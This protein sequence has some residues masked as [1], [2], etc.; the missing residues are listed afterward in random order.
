M[1]EILKIIK[2]AQII[3]LLTPGPSVPL[4]GV[5]R[6]PLRPLHRHDRGHGHREAGGHHLVHALPRGQRAR[7]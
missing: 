4:P 6:R 2:S 7:E 5:G 1:Q 3:A